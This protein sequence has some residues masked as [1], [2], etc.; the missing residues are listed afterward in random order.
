MIMI[1]TAWN[2]GLR[3]ESGAGYGVKLTAADRDR[4]LSKEW[5]YI[6]L[7]LPNRADAVVVNVSKASFWSKHCRE[8]IL[9]DIGLWFQ[10]ID[11]AHWPKGKPPKFVLTHLGLNQFSLS[12]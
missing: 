4:F 11:C 3:K 12:R 1:V 8:L 10:S 2:N 7:F 5:S 9:K 6:H